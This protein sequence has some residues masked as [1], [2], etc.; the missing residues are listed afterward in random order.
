[1]KTNRT[2]FFVLIANLA[3]LSVLFYFFPKVPLPFI[4]PSFLDLQL[5]NLPA[6]IGGYALGPL[7]GG[8]IV[9]VRTLIKLPFST[10]AYVGETVDLIIGLATVITSSVIY[11][12]VHTK[13]GAFIGMLAGMLAWVSIAV[14]ANWL[15]VL[16]FYLEAFFGGNLDALLGLLQII[17]GINESNYM[18][19][20][21]LYAILPF[22]LL[23][24][25]I[26]YGITFIVYKRISGLIQHLN[27]RFTRDQV[28]PENH[29]IYPE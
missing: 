18:G 17:P 25:A 20:Y 27:E 2:L 13:K 12:K 28:N 14:L 19:R 10:T 16:D 23:L 5:S 8:L 9:V 4:F 29:E 22:N 3:A 7:A 15:F 21:I 24:S 1:M 11:K 6:I 26:V